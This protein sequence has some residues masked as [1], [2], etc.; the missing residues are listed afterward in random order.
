MVIRNIQLRKYNEMMAAKK[1]AERQGLN[2]PKEEETPPEGQ[3]PKH[4]TEE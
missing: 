2:K 1:K 4:M 3:D